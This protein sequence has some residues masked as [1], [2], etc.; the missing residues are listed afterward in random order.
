MTYA[1]STF[2]CTI[3]HLVQTCLFNAVDG[4]YSIQIRVLNL[5]T[6]FPV[7]VN[8]DMPLTKGEIPVPNTHWHSDVTGKHR[9]TP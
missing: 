4:Q 1:R 5:L 6:I 3:R 7:S 9:P 2:I 8:M